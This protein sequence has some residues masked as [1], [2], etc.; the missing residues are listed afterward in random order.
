[1]TEY[2]ISIEPGTWGVVIPDLPGCFSAG[3]SLAS[4]IDNAGQAARARIQP[5]VDDGGTVHAPQSL[6]VHR[7][8]PEFTGWSWA[9]IR[10][11][12]A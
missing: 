5:V 2:P 7:E 3:D 8:N 12:I 9:M 6:A 1:M 11:P 10:V 4:A